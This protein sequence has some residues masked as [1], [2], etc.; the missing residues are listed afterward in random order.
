MNNISPNIKQKNEQTNGT[1][2]SHRNQSNS[3]LRGG[4][5]CL[6]GNRGKFSGEME[7]F[8]IL[9]GV[10]LALGYFVTE[11]YTFVKTH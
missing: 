10:L 11:A 2:C 9:I 3:C 7:M 5:N 1:V 6:E 8:C 4:R